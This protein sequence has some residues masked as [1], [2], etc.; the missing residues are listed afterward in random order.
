MPLLGASEPNFA[1]EPRFAANREI[2]RGLHR[3]AFPR[4]FQKLVRCLASQLPSF[5][6]TGPTASGGLFET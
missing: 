6:K 2:A 5:T 4:S 3:S 1:V